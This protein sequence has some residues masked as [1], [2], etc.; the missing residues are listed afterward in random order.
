M[1]TNDIFNSLLAENQASLFTLFARSPFDFFVLVKYYMKS[2]ICRYIDGEYSSYQNAS[3]KLLFSYLIKEC[4]EIARFPKKNDVN[5]EAARWLGYF[6]RRWNI[7]TKDYSSHIVSELTPLE[8]IKSYF[9]LHQMNENQAIMLSKRKYNLARNAHRVYELKSDSF[10]IN[11]IDE[12]LYLAFIKSILIKL[13]GTYQ[14]KSLEENYSK[15]CRYDL[16]SKDRSVGVILKILNRNS[17]NEIK[18]I[19]KEE[20]EELMFSKFSANDSNLFFLIKENIDQESLEDE[21]NSLTE[22]Y[23]SNRNKFDNVFVF[24]SNTLYQINKMFEL[25]KFNLGVK[26]SKVISQSKNM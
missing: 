2:Q 26:F 22:L 18:N 20:N 4:P 10:N 3:P 21:L 9:V 5:V 13:Y 19:F 8:G 24:N 12:N 15:D 7:L 25:T 14:Y 6:Y 16:I 23:L 17:L 11:E 1:E